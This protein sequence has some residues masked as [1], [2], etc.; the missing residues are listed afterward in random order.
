MGAG[1]GMYRALRLLGQDASV[2]KQQVKPDT[3]RRTVR[4][5]RPY[6]AWLGLFLLV[7]VLDAA[8]SVINPLL[9]RA[10]I[11]H[12][13]LEHDPALIVRLAAVLAGLAVVDAGLGLAAD[14]P[15]LDRGRAHRDG[16]ARAFVPRHHP[17][18]P[19]L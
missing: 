12:G 14:R 9:D 18:Q 3:L 15:G 8:V 17:R 19:A 11:D 13:I 2:L 10:I 4:F 7:V 1:A 6:S 16:A 5:A